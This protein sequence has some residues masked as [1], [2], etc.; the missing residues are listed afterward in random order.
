MTLTIN[1]VIIVSREVPHGKIVEAKICSSIS[2]KLPRHNSVNAGTCSITST[3]VAIANV[4]NKSYHCF[5]FKYGSHCNSINSTLHSCPSFM[6]IILDTWC[7]WCT[8]NRQTS[9]QYTHTKHIENLT[10]SK[11]CACCTNLTADSVADLSTMPIALTS[12]K[13]WHSK[14]HHVPP[15]SLVIVL[16]AHAIAS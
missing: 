7:E 11:K 12:C 15:C 4:S 3:P 10:V 9:G 5:K 16:L 13:K 2:S 6:Y 8:L 1:E 14:L